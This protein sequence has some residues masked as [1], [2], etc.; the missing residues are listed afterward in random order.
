M[1][2]RAATSADAEAIVDMFVVL[3]EETQFLLYEP[4]ERD[5][6]V[7]SLANRLNDISSSERDTFL[8]ATE[9]SKAMGFCAGWGGHVQR[10]RH[11]LEII[12]G[13]R[14]EATR[15]GL[16]RQLLSR[17]ESWARE[18][19]FTRLELT[20]MVHNTH[21]IALY[22]SLGFDVEGTRR[23]SLRVNNEPVDEFLMA[24]ILE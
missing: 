2:I 18:R 1:E 7:E 14:Q 12:I 17:L 20:V 4:G 19:D 21:A 16:G 24:R 8:I 13:I 22:R 5:Q 9:G 11:R 10:N 3:D 23:H 6:S 15:Q